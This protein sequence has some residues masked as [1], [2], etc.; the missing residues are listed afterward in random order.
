MAGVKISNLPAA[1]VPLT[2]AELIAVVQGGATK[3]VAIN[4]TTTGSN[5]VSY[6]P[7]GTG[8]VATTVQTKLRENV[9]VKDFGAVGNGS[10]NDRSAI[11]AAQ[12]AVAG[13]TLFFTPGTYRINSNLTIT[14]NCQFQAGAKLNPASGV[15]ITMTGSIGADMYQIIDI[16]AGG[17]VDLRGAKID[18][19]CVEWWGVVGGDAAFSS[20]NATINKPLIDEALTYCAPGELWFKQPGI[21]STTGHAVTGFTKLRI[22]G[23]G[24]SSDGVRTGIR[25]SGIPFVYAA[26]MP[27]TDPAYYMS[28]I[29]QNGLQGAG[30]HVQFVDI[31]IVASDT[32]TTTVVPIGCLVST[33]VTL[34][35][36]MDVSG[37]SLLEGYFGLHMTLS[38]IAT[39]GPDVVY[40]GNGL[41]VNANNASFPRCSGGAAIAMTV[42]SLVYGGGSTNIAGVQRTN[43]TGGILSNSGSVSGSLLYQ[44]QYVGTGGSNI[45][46]VK[47]F[48]T[49]YVGP[50]YDGFI[51]DAQQQEFFGVTF[52]QFTNELLPVVERGTSRWIEPYGS[53]SIGDLLQTTSLVNTLNWAAGSQVDLKGQMKGG[54]LLVW[55]PADA[56]GAGLVFTSV[57][58]R[59][60]L[61]GNMVTA[62][63]SL[64]YPATANGSNVLISGLPFVV[65]NNQSALSVAAV[66]TTAAKVC[67]VRANNNSSN[68]DILNMSG[69]TNVINSDL[70]GKSIRATLTYPFYPT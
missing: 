38:Y 28:Y 70:T 16:S 18:H 29:F 34:N 37:S 50:A 41:T 42:P 45:N 54:Q 21:Y 11:V 4:Q 47:W 17:H 6:L 36:H 5:L 40:I 58:C 61:T 30:N 20:G 55:T 53:S 3:Q 65:A 13:N 68:F 46:T 33:S 32:T 22:C 39:F 63:I 14:A 60:T 15:T 59:Y 69:A 35:A 26:E 51:L 23:V 49:G 24:L 27:N 43:F 67:C 19:S 2:G 56:S 31:S 62:Y 44:F 57:D 64:T 10:T 1:T 66:V 25:G 12:T 52:E 9:S 48:G 8:A 7:A